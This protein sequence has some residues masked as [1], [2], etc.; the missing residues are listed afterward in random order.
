MAGYTGNVRFFTDSKFPRNY[1]K[2]VAEIQE[3]LMVLGLLARTSDIAFADWDYGEMKEGLKYAR[4]VDVTRFKEGAASEIAQKLSGSGEELFSFEIYFDPNQNSFPASQYRAEF[5]RIIDFATTYGGALITI[6]GHT[7]PMGYLRK[8]KE[9][10]DDLV[11][12]KIRQAAKNLSYSRADA[13]RIEI[14]KYAA[15]KGV[16]L[17]TSQFNIIG[18]GIDSPKYAVPKTEDEWHHNMR[19]QFKVF[20][21]EAEEQVFRPLQ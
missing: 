14:I 5:D 21:V 20:Q 17:D 18:Q 9:G 16:K 13:A 2:L 3:S 11:L 15:S 8:Q 19:V 6:E 12:K 1:R 7:D 4:D 10:A